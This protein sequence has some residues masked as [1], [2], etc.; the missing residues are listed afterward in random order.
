LDG[1]NIGFMAVNILL[2]FVSVYKLRKFIS[3]SKAG[4]TSHLKKRM[5][6]K[7][8]ESKT[9]TRG[10]GESNRETKITS[11]QRV[12]IA[13]PPPLFGSH[14]G[15][16]SLLSRPSNASNAAT[17]TAAGLVFGETDVKK[18]RAVLSN[19]NI[20][21]YSV[22]ACVFAMINLTVGLNYILGG[23][24]SVTW[25]STGLTFFSENIFNYYGTSYI[26]NIYVIV[27]QT[28]IHKKGKDVY[29]RRAV[30][31][32]AM[33]RLMVFTGSVLL[34]V[35]MFV[36]SIKVAAVEIHNVYY[37]IVTFLWIVLIRLNTTLLMR[38]IQ[39]SIDQKHNG[40]GSGARESSALEGVSMPTNHSV[41]VIPKKTHPSVDNS[42]K[43]PTDTTKIQDRTRSSI[44]KQRE[45]E[46]GKEIEK[47]KTIWQM[48]ILREFSTVIC[49][50]CLACWSLFYLPSYRP[51]T[52]RV[53]WFIFTLFVL[54]GQLTLKS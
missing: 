45:D 21:R 18:I 46:Q 44:T 49:M 26:L 33:E 29:L 13:T 53:G 51:Y 39:K 54:L 37:M 10:A 19:T 35:S 9:P 7:I 32:T 12:T 41:A 15:V 11:P 27:L 31:F 40:G 8:V 50:L 25:G 38:R 30:V 14:V 47:R 24:V 20:G 34:N 5:S 3:H 48:R 1:I 52:F 4:L 17:V 23:A 43:Q 36:P 28:S 2:L 6:R 22:L 42:S 16:L